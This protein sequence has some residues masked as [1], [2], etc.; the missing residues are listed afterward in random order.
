MTH[1]EKLAH[2]TRIATMHLEDAEY[3]IVYEDE[4]LEDAT[5]EEWQEIHDMITSM[6]PALPNEQEKD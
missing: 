2:A 6:V 1:E 3:G 5:E 4:A